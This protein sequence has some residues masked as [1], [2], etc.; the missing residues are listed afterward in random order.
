MFLICS[1]FTVMAKFSHAIRKHFQ[2]NVFKQGRFRS[3]QASTYQ[4][5]ICSQSRKCTGYT[6][7]LGNL[8]FLAL[9]LS[10]LY[11]APALALQHIK[12]ANKI[13]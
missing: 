8:F 10:R 9:Q 6:C 2:V 4:H 3:V 12:L 1:I 13:V 11:I 7:Y 5:I